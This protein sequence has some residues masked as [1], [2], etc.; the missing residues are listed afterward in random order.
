[1]NYSNDTNKK[2][3]SMYKNKTLKKDSF[4][5]EVLRCLYSDGII[6]ISSSLCDDVYLSDKGEAYIEDMLENI[7]EKRSK[8]YING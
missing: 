8:K 1:M 5:F 4:S 3:V 6:R 7:D 2:L